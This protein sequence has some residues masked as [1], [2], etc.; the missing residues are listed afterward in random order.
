M[1]GISVRINK[2]LYDS[3]VKEARAE[4]RTAPQQINFWAKIGR[5]ALANPDLPVEAIR[6]ILIAKEE[7][8]EPFSFGGENT[9]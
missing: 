5:N 4:Y 8:S 1:T 6:D 7:E 3:A 9:P 2:D